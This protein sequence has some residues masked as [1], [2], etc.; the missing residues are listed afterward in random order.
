MKADRMHDRDIDS[1]YHLTGEEIQRKSC[2][3]TACFVARHLNTGR[4]PEHAGDEKRVY[5]LGKCY[6][7]PASSDDNGRPE[8]YVQSR[9]SIIL[10][11]IVDG[12]ARTL[13][14]YSDRGGY[15]TLEKV[16]G[17]SRESLISA[18]EAS[19]LRGRGPRCNYW[20]TARRNNSA[21]TIRHAARIRRTP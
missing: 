5:C 11:R 9:E 1:F 15:S 20:R 3:G 7:A 21:S 4:V 13:Q 8:V 16:L 17:Q 14:E 10:S 19:G 12:G 2:L 6:A 18:I